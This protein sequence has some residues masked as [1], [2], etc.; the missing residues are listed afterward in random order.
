MKE[1]VRRILLMLVV[2]VVMAAMMAITA[3]PGFA[4]QPSC[5]PRECGPPGSFGTGITQAGNHGVGSER[6]I[7]IARSHAR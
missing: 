1:I 4:A 3:G 2:A 5:H 7:E 6:G